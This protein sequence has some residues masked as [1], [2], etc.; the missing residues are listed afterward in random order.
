MKRPLPVIAAALL[1]VALV[2]LVLAW[3]EIG[4]LREEVAALKKGQAAAKPPSSSRFGPATSKTEVAASSKPKAADKSRVEPAEEKD[5]DSMS[6]MAALVGAG[7]GQI[8]K[9]RKARVALLTQRLK[10]RPEQTAALEKHAETYSEKVKAAFERMGKDAARPPDLGILMD[11]TS[12]RFDLPIKD[13][14]DTEQAKLFSDFD[15]EDRSNRI[16]NLV[17]A[18]LAELHGQGTIQLSPEQKDKV[19]EALTG[20]LAAEDAMGDAYFADDAGFSARI[21]ES[22]ARRREALKSI[23]DASQLQ[24]Y[25]RVLEEDRALIK[26]TFPSSHEAAK[27]K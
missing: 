2:L 16:E 14:L 5:K 15:A 13:L 23:F 22:L 9:R 7:K 19:F 6:G 3:R 26:G 11:W 21:D 18:E 4:S 27:G 1:A 10:L 20:I 25:V 12:G 17:N 8:E 24:D